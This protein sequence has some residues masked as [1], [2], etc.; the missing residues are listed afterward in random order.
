MTDDISPFSEHPEGDAKS[1]LVEEKEDLLREA[2][3]DLRLI[4]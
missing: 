3:S 4:T 2:I 1:R